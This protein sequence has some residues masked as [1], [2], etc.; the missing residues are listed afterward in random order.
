[1]DRRDFL[2]TATLAGVGAA[3]GSDVFGQRAARSLVEATVAELSA[4][5]Q[6]GQMTSEQITAW[7]LAR[8]RTVDPQINSMIEITRTRSPSLGRRTANEEIG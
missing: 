2:S 1:M 5:M 7:Y 6:K 4:M 8:I 3:L